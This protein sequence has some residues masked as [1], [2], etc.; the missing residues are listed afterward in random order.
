MS[1][2]PNEQYLSPHLMSDPKAAQAYPVLAHASEGGKAR[3][4]ALTPDRRHEIASLAAR[5]RWRPKKAHQRIIR[6]QAALLDARVP[7]PNLAGC[8]V[9]ACDKATAKRIILKY[10]W[11]G[12]LG[13]SF[14]CYALY[15]ASSEVLGVV[16]FGPGPGDAA[17]NVCGTEYRDVAV[18]LERGACVHFAPKN[19]G[20]YLIRHAVKLA[21]KEHGWEIFY[22]YAD[23]EA[24]EIGT[25]YQASNWKYLGPSRAGRD[26][27]KLVRPNG[28]VVDERQLRSGGVKLN[29][30][31]GWRRI[32]VSAKGRYVW[33][34]GPR[35]RKLRAL[36]R[37][38]FLKYPK[39]EGGVR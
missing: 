17:R 9:R 12:T 28:H 16:S 36:C 18:C 19:A 20:S 3:A 31:I 2:E 33:F 22:A 14:A 13:R 21:H 10:E 4:D 39:R 32:F 35:R 25:V 26:R 38:P 1:P 34:E 8:V 29:D 27:E 5:A 24:G 15:S 30:V 11:L 37:F 7:L 23:P 6:E